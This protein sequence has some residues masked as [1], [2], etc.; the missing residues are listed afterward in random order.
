MTIADIITVARQLSN[1]DATA[2]PAITAPSTINILG[3]NINVAIETL[4]SKIIQVC[5]N[6]PHDD[7]NFGNIA[8]G[9][10]ALEEGISKYT[11]TDKFLDIREIKVKDS[12]GYFHIVKPRTQKESE[13]ILE[14]LEAETG[15]P[16]HYRIIGRTLFLSPA[17]TASAVTLTAGLKFFY[18]RTSYQITYADF[19]A[20]FLVPGIASPWHITIAKMAALPFCKTYKKDQVAQLQLDIQTEIEDMLIFYANRQKDRDNRIIPKVENCR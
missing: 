1:S 6:F 9:T 11:I 4:V 5:R 2:Y 12:S 18:T 17:P 8:E 14:T 7:E 10:I 16:T 20:G 19:S 15:L 13:A 3:I